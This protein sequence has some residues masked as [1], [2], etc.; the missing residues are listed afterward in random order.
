VSD[1]TRH[2]VVESDV[3]VRFKRLIEPDVNPC[4]RRVLTRPM[5]NPENKENK[6]N[7]ENLKCLLT[8]TRRVINIQNLD[9]AR[10]QSEQKTR[11]KND[12]QQLFDFT[13]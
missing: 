11:T 1:Q 9:S 12:Y 3:V 5:E 6:E 10:H 4:R 2:G 7:P 8:F 13:A